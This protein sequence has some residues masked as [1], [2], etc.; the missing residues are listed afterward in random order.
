MNIDLELKLLSISADIS[1]SRLKV[2]KEFGADHT[3]QVDSSGSG[4]NY[5]KKIEELLGTAPDISVECSG[6]E[7]SIKLAILVSNVGSKIS[8]LF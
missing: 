1:E 3:L 5:A 8:I 4:A 6:A 7:S 2:A